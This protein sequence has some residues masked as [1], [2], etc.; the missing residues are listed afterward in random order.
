MFRSIYFVATLTVLFVTFAS[1]DANAE[2]MKN[3]V[4]EYT[5]NTKK[6]LP[7]NGACTAD[8]IAVRKEWYAF[9]I[10]YPRS[11]SCEIIKWLTYFSG[12]QGQSKQP[13]S[14]GIHQSR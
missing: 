10:P 1:V 6:R 5:R 2:L 8:K 11:M 13:I 4:K 12:S 3:L 14:S 7:H 9:P